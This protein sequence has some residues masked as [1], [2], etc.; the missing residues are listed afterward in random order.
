MP[1][2]LHHSRP[3]LSPTIDEVLIVI[4]SEIDRREEGG[5]A[6]D[7]EFLTCVSGLL[8]RIAKAEAE[9]QKQAAQSRRE[10]WALIERSGGLVDRMRMSSLLWLILKA[11]G[12]SVL[13]DKGIELLSDA[14]LPPRDARHRRRGAA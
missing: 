13:S 5:E 1:Q 4:A 6:Q 7:V 2:D 14:M 12:H 10:D 8:K 11:R 9:R 3:F